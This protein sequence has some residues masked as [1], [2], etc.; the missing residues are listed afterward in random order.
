MKNLMEK[1]THLRRIEGNKERGGSMDGWMDGW[2]DGRMDGVHE[3]S[4]NYDG[5]SKE[6]W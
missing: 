4:A 5:W 6:I 3:M 2:M 1:K